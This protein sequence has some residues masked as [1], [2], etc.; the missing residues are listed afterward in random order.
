MTDMLITAIEP[1]RRSLSALFIDG[2]HA[3]DVD[4]ETLLQSPFKI[5]SE[6]TDEELRELIESSDANRAKSRAMYLLSHRDHS[7]KEL[8]DK[9]RR[10]SS[11]KAAEEAVGRMQ[12]LGLID[13]A[14]YAERYAAQLIERKH[15]SARRAEYELIQKGIDRDV[16]RAAVEALSPDP[17]EQIAE[18]LRRKYPQAGTD[19]GVRRRAVAA[20]Q[21]LGF[22]YEDIRS[23]LRQNSPAEGNEDDLIGI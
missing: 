14:S 2:E 21:R 18:M 6:I 16:A 3:A 11:D 23:V 5:G 9:L 17:K 7:Q 22:S 19:E 1:R 10:F 20:L 12:E 4:K 13:D 8:K 15:F